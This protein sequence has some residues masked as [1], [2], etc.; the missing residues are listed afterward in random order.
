MRPPAARSLAA[1]LVPLCLLVLGMAVATRS[2]VRYELRIVVVYT[3][4]AGL[5]A[6]WVLRSGRQDSAADPATASAARQA[7]AADPAGGPAVVG[8]AL[9]ATFAL[10]AVLHLKVRPYTYLSPG[11]G[12]L[13]RYVLAASAALVALAMLGSVL[14]GRR[15]FAD[16]GLGAA[17]VGYLIAA[18]MLIH[19]DPTPKIDVWVTL[20]QA[21][22]GILRGD[23]MYAQNWSGS[24]GVQDAFTY[25]P[26]TG[27]LLA[28]GRWLAGDV[29]WALVVVTLLGVLA[30][31]LLGR[32]EPTGSPDSALS[33]G[34]ASQTRTLAATGAAALI[35]LLPGT[36]TQVEQ[37]WT[38]PLLMAC[39]AGW[40]LGVHRNNTVLAVV[41]L[42]L[43]VASKQHLIVLL[44]ILA[45]WPQ[46]G[47]RK[48]VAAGGLAGLFVLP[49]IIASPADIWHDTVT[50]LVNFQPLIFAD[51]LFIAAVNDLSW[52]PPFW[53]TGAAVLITLAAAV[54]QVHRRNPDL[55]TVLRWGALF[56]F[57]ANLVNK[58]AFYNQYWLV[59]SLVVISL[60]VPRSQAAVSAPEPIRPP[61]TAEA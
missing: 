61:A 16:A 60:A 36:P 23:N 9:A 17:V 8:W 37:G 45:A 53:L 10:V 46:F 35:L 39:L 6:F 57:V 54:I 40:A 5:L 33:S 14:T 49:W 34:T 41:C 25:L 38:E 30:V 1:T 42:A 52:T 13:V 11:D 2:V 32:S 21:A 26:F 28:P 44:P 43:G 55:G 24:P 51:T 48:A 59:A 19:L 18:V 12:W 15:R 29:R 27:L 47:L 3:V 7:P 50:T 31:R 4:L 58:Q 56:L 22:D 20:Q